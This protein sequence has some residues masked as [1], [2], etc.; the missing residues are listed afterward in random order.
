[1]ATSFVAVSACCPLC[2]SRV[3]SVARN[4]RVLDKD[5]HPVRLGEELGRGYSLCDDCGILA[6]L[7]GDLTLN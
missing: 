1:M 2:G 7:P 4:G 6:N 5:L 3:L